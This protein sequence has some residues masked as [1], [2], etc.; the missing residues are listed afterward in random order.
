MTIVA[1]ATMVAGRTKL[2][3]E[4]ESVEEEAEGELSKLIVCVSLQA[5]RPVSL[6][7]LKLGFLQKWGLASL[8]FV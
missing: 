6:K 3:V 7:T 5:L 1:A 4:G 2:G 8:I